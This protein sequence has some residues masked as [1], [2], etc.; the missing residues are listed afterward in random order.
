MESGREDETGELI[1]RFVV[2]GGEGHLFLFDES[3]LA[4]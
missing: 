4:R 3:S 1:G 2:T